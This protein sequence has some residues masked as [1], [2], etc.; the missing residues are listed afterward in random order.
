[1]GQRRRTSRHD[2]RIR[3]TRI[4]AMVAGLIAL[5][6]TTGVLPIAGHARGSVAHANPI[7][8]G[9]SSSD[10]ADHAAAIA[11]D[12]ARTPRPG[13]DSAGTPTQHR[14]RSS[15]SLVV[16][17]A[18]AMA[19]HRRPARASQTVGTLPSSSKYYHVALA[20]WVEKVS[21]D[22]RWGRV[23]I[24]YVW[25]RRAGWIPLDGLRRSTTHVEVEVDLSRHRVM[26]KKFGKVR[27]G[28]S[29]ATGSA[30]SPTPPGEYFVTDR[31]PFPSGGSLGSF[32]FGISGIQPRLPAGWSGGNQ[33][34]IHG[35]DQPSTIG[36]SASAG[37]IR[38]GEKSLRRLLPM[39][40]LG[41]PV[42]IHS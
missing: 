15:A 24:P 14:S 29:A 11:A 35:T 23:E 2:D 37:C 8:A 1:M 30:S 40:Q 38:V 33:L 28:F 25:P 39:L 21:P 22:G 18:S 5:S 9:S 26:V 27:Y 4:A 10:A 16:R 20:A 34:A 6:A 3:T 19:V 32:A 36:T 17:V 12:T 42:I 7:V 13:L 31:I 41:T